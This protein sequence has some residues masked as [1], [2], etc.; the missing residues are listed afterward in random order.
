VSEQLLS[1]TDLQKWTGYTRK[2]DIEKFCNKNGIKIIRAKGGTI[3]TTLAAIEKVFRGKS[4]SNDDS[5]DDF[6][7]EFE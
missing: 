1:E 7:I 4:A 3:C 5:N 6:P 2:A